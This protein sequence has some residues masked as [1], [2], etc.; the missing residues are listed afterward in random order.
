MIH[1]DSDCGFALQDQEEVAEWIQQMI[2]H[3]GYELGFLDIIFRDDTQI[4]M[5]NNLHLQHDYPTDIL[6]FDY[7]EDKLIQAE[8]HI[9]IEEVQR[10]AESLAVA[11]VDEIHRV[12]IHGL[13]H[14][15]NFDDKTEDD[16][17]RMRREE[18][19]MLAMRMF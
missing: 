1:F 4:Q 7:S 19:K 11:F 16:R 14:M 13:L 3:Q 8:L 15:T 12:L 10:N 6:T 17:I 9:G 2:H 18:D 5:L